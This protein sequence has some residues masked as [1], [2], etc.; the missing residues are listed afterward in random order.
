M[1]WT[2]T[3]LGA[4]RGLSFGVI[5]FL[6]FHTIHGVLKAKITFWSPKVLGRLIPPWIQGRNIRPRQ[7]L[8]IFPAIGYSDWFGHGQVSE[9]VQTTFFLKMLMGELCWL[10]PAGC[11]KVSY[12][13]NFRLPFWKCKESQLF[14]EGSVQMKPVLRV[15]LWVV[16]TSGHC[17]CKSPLLLNRLSLVFYY[18][19][20]DSCFLLEFAYCS[21]ICTVLYTINI[22][23]YHL[24]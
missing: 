20:R 3:D 4:G 18:L 1:Y 15:G 8:E 14:K 5:S 22:R 17:V 16:P 9:R 23:N 2:P 24:F 21:K 12:P 13:R 6:P 11:K 10:L 19:W 7:S